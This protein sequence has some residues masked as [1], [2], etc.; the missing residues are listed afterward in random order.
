MA[1]IFDEDVGDAPVYAPGP[2]KTAAPPHANMFDEDVA[3]T[4]APAPKGTDWSKLNKP[5]GE[6]K[7]YDPSWTQ[8][9]KDKLQDA[10]SGIGMK[11][12]AAQHISGGLVD[13][14]RAITPMG[15][16]LSGA[17]AGYHLRRGEY[18]D[19][20]WDALGVVPSAFTAGKRLYQGMPKTA[21]ADVPRMK[22]DPSFLAE[23]G[24]P[25]PYGMRPYDQSSG[26]G[27]SQ[28]RP[29]LPA[30]RA[31]DE[32]QQAGSQAYR[33]SRYSPI[34]YH[35]RAMN[36]FVA[37]ALQGLE[38]PELGFSPEKAP[39]VHSTLRRWA[40]QMNYRNTP[41][42][43]SD[44]DTLRSQLKGMEGVDGAAGSRVADWLDGYMVRPP[45]GAVLRGTQGDLDALQRTFDTARGNWRSYKTSEAVAKEIDRAGTRAGGKN[46][47]LNTGNMTRDKLSALTSTDA[48]EAK[49]FG[50]RPDEI[51]AI[52]DVVAGDPWTNALR[53]GS[54]KLAGGGG[55]GSTGLGIMAG[56]AG[57]AAGHLMGL[58]PY[59]S[60]AFGTGAG[61]GIGKAGEAMRVASNERTVQAAND[62]VNLIRQNSPEYAARVRATPDI[63]DPLAM[64]RDAITYALMPQISQEGQSVWD[65]A[66]VPYENRAPDP[67]EAQSVP[68]DQ[69]APPLRRVYI[70]QPA[71]TYD[72]QLEQ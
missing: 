67:A 29:P 19:A 32:L 46:S 42:T 10:L 52:N 14:G 63:T 61:L 5:F 45:P 57:T 62:V 28:P 15:T 31:V 41:I 7:P 40:D 54:N 44:F 55:A 16:V 38:H 58:D 56:S 60:M 9:T 25:D 30:P 53:T 33:D 34:L 50:A 22:S 17:D 18:G 65:Q 23:R 37:Q 39:I 27:W 47:G 51:S 48:G 64:R 1:G 36:D 66:H 11:L 13:L 49:I 6:L 12:P 70:D 68:P 71:E 21:M 8:W 69:P 24:K 20:A 43:A 3:G 2:P 59:T 26:I 35:P 72:P 4:P